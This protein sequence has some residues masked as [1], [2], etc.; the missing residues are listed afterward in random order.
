MLRSGPGGLPRSSLSQKLALGDSTR[1]VAEELAAPFQTQPLPPT[2][3]SHPPRELAAMGMGRH[4]LSLAESDPDRNFRK[5]PSPN[6]GQEM[7]Q[8]GR[9]APEKSGQ[10]L[11]LV[12][13]RKVESGRVQEP[14]GLHVALLKA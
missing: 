3:D 8:G 5:D 4:C 2:P 14:P 10:A 7:I 13:Q 9:G 11:P 6:A 1:C 12:T